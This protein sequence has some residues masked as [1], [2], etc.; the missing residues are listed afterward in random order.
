[1]EVNFVPELQE[2]IQRIAAENHRDPGEVV[3]E[4]VATYLEQ[5]PWYREKVEASIARLDK[6]EYLTTE[7]MGERLETLFNS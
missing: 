7:E 3:Q 1:M 6:G 5:E 4:I 2:K